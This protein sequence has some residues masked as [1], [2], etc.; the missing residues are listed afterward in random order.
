MR[1][2]RPMAALWKLQ[3]A[4][5]SLPR[6]LLRVKIAHMRRRQALLAARPQPS[7]SRKGSLSPPRRNLLPVRT[8]Q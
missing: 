1:A 7:T 4:F 8:L 5:L 3:E 2:S 6:R